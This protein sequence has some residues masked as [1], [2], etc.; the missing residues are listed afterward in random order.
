MEFKEWLETHD[1]DFD[2]ES[3]YSGDI[4]HLEDAWNA[5]VKAAGRDDL[6]STE[7]R[8]RFEGKG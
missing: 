1:P 6:I 2:W 5:G 8:A 3:E 4:A 7:Y